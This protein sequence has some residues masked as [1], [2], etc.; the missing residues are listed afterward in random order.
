MHC[1]RHHIATVKDLLHHRGVQ[2]LR[3]AASLG[4]ARGDLFVH[5]G[6][7]RA[8]AASEISNPQLP[9]GFGIIPIYAVQLAHCQ[10]RQQGRRRRQC[11]ESRQIL[12]VGNQ[13]LKYSPC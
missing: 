8:G 1:R 7:Q 13:P 2:L 4:M 9:D 3:I 6:Q 12:T 11:V 10:A 5:R